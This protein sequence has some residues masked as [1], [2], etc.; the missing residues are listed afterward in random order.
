MSPLELN[1]SEE[2]T[3]EF[4]AETTIARGLGYAR[5]LIASQNI[6]FPSQW[7]F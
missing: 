1:G 7:L 6:K 5:E 2:N 3:K 4:R